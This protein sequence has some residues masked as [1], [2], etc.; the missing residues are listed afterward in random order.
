MSDQRSWIAIFGVIVAS[1]KAAAVVVK[2]FQQKIW[3]RGATPPQEIDTFCPVLFSLWIHFLGAFFF[4]DTFSP[5]D[6]EFPLLKLIYYLWYIM[7]MVGWDKLGG[8][9]WVGGWGVPIWNSWLTDW[10]LDHLTDWNR[11]VSDWSESTSN[12][13]KW[14]LMN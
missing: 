6:D 7:S 2:G 14:F 10:P 9:G 8:G 11:Y 3:T 1:D 12:G 4:M 13:L 5:V